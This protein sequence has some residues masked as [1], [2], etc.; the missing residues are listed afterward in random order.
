[1]VGTVSGWRELDLDGAVALVAAR[2]AAGVSARGRADLVV[3][4]G[5]GPLR[6]FAALRRRGLPGPT[7]RL[8]LSDERCVPAG[9]PRRNADGVAAALG[10]DVLGPP[11]GTDPA[12]AAAGW[13]DALAAV[14]TLDVTVLGLG[15]DGHVA[16]IFP[17]DPGPVAADASD[18]VTAGPSAAPPA[19]VTLSAGRLRRTGALLL[20]VDGPGKDV[21]VAGVRAGADTGLPTTRLAGPPRWLVDLR[22]A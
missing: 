3:P 8:H 18:A 15:Q 1:M 12:V 7:W 10:A 20:V 6:L 14:G 9:D 16:G 2:A 13:S 4:G 19:R 21:A 22:G 17:G 5:R 11:P